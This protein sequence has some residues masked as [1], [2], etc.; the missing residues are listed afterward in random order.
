MSSREKRRS[1]TAGLPPGTLM[2]IGQ[3]KGEQVHL[4]ILSYEP[5]GVVERYLQKIEE[6]FPYLHQE[7]LDWISVRG[8]H[9]PD[10]VSALG[11]QLGL[12]L[13]LQEDVLNT[14]QRPKMDRMEK[15][16]LILMKT[17]SFQSDGHLQ[18][19]QLSL[20]LGENYLVTFEEGPLDYFHP[21]RQRMLTQ[22]QG[23]A[24]T[25]D[26][27]AYVLIDYVVD[28]YFVVLEQMGEK[29]QSL[30]DRLLDS[31][32]REI[33]AEIQ[34]TKKEIIMLRR[35]V[36]PMRGIVDG[37]T[38]DDLISSNTILYLKDVYEHLIEAMEMVE[39]Y[40]DSLSGLVDIYLTSVSNRMNEVMKTLTIIA[41][42]FIPLTFITGIYGMNFHHMPE[43]T[44]FWGY[45][46][47]M[48]V[49]VILSVLMLSYFRRKKWF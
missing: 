37:L 29:L 31:P 49:M 3:K 41:T 19:E 7:G 48:V 36:W 43:L 40:R 24:P 26:F 42:I 16:I 17:L 11:D 20:A 45:P 23:N 44:W 21:I 30:E 15:S 14:T 6:S 33:M 4:N 38:K 32:D 12:H 34:K 22:H 5:E 13:L 27:L 25:A 28:Q 46:L 9:R 47:V 2:H 1:K 35:S 18:E 8:L 10:I 39:I